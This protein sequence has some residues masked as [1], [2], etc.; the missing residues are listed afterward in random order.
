MK[1][2]KTGLL[3]PNTIS[4]T[5]Y[6]DSLLDD[7][8]SSL[9]KSIE[10]EGI[11]EPIVITADF[12]IISG[13]RRY[14]A[15][16]ELGMDEVPVIISTALE[17]QVDEYMV[18]SHQQQRV[19]SAVQV[20]REIEIINAKYNLKQGRNSSDPKVI[21]GKKERGK[22]GNLYSDSTLERL[23]DARKNLIQLH[24]GDEKKA[25]EELVLMGKKGKSV[26]QIQREAAQMRK[27]ETNVRTISVATVP[28]R[29]ERYRIFNGD[30]RDLSVVG[31][32]SVDCVFTSPPYF[33]F[34]DYQ[35][36]SEQIGV[37]RNVEDFIEN[38]VRVFMEC[39]RTMKPTASMFINIMDSFK[40]GVLL[41]VPGKLKQALIDKGFLFVSEIIWVKNNP[42]WTYSKRPQPCFEYIFHF[43][44]TKNYRYY[45][46]WMTDLEFEGSVCYG[47]LGKNRQLRSFF[48]Y[49][50]GIVQTNGANNATLASIMAGHGYELTHSATMPFEVAAIGVLSVT[51]EGDHVLDPFNG[52]ATT[53]LAAI[54]HGRFYTG[55]DNN[56]QYIEM[57]KLRL[58]LFLDKGESGIVP[59][60]PSGSSGKPVPMAA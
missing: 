21:E 27:N 52:L 22:L 56:P 50:N 47:D 32:E 55:I 51:Q 28:Q 24:N 31:T 57:A 36:G 3:R 16:L 8:F 60:V 48:D 15:A 10:L 49:R 18:I 5:I 26:L 38:L 58:N 44:K 14:F 25:W 29:N 9:K 2:V 42:A 17:A 7:N 13:V 12:F 45:R 20:L 59:L 54:S 6:G 43:A 46:D 19:K 37:E 34:R 33:N 23:R 35:T 1:K 4:S 30:S 11:L 40:D 39:S 41:N 53:G